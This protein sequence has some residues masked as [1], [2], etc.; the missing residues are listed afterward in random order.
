[1]L[2]GN[3][4][5]IR[6][7]GP[8]YLGFGSFTWWV[9]TLFMVGSFCFAIGTVIAVSAQPEASGIVYFVGSIFFTTAGYGQLLSAINGTELREPALLG[10]GFP[11]RSTGRPRRS[12]PSGR[13]ASTSAPGSRS[14]SP[15]ST[16]SRPTA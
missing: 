11:A 4:R 3:G 1:M 10:D 9:A 2:A 16:R 14:W 6:S 15:C 8:F 5:L 12:S 7:F 13:S